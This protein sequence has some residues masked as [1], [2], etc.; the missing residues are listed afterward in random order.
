MKH[1]SNFFILLVFSCVLTLHPE[2]LGPETLVK[3]VTKFIPLH[4]CLVNDTILACDDIHIGTYTIDL[5]EA[6][7][8]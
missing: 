5:T 1:L 3:T 7:G 8:E 2:G 6:I 4:T